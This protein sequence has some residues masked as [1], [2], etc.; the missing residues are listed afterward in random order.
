MRMGAEPGFME[1]PA[2]AV[3]EVSID[4]EKWFFGMSA[5][6]SSWAIVPGRLFALSPQVNA[7]PCLDIV[8][9]R[10]RMGRRAHL[11]GRTAAVSSGRGSELPVHSLAEGGSGIRAGAALLE[12]WTKTVRI[13]E[14]G[15]ASAVGLA[16]FD[17]AG[18]RLDRY[19]MSLRAE[20]GTL[21][22]QMS[23]C[24]GLL[25]FHQLAGLEALQKSL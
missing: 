23:P 5:P 21:L 10:A 20:F 12:K 19:L 1:K 17:E 16:H 7:I 14:L 6:T 18:I 22:F 11:I 15:F 24:G 2:R 25:L 13:R 9:G 8:D 3:A 4:P